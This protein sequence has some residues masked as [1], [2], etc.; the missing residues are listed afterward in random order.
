MQAIEILEQHFEAAKIKYPDENWKKFDEVKI[1]QEFICAAME[2]YC[3][4]KTTDL[5]QQLK[6]ET[7]LRKRWEIEY[8]ELRDHLRKVIESHEES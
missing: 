1:E 2:E 4:M 8:Y 7:E 3:D 6:T 5:K